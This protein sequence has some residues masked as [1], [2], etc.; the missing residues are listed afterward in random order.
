MDDEVEDAPESPPFAELQNAIANLVDDGSMLAGFVV[1]AEWIE[2]DGR[3]T[4]SVFGSPMPPWHRYGMLSAARDVHAEPLV[5]EGWDED[6]DD[7]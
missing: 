5:L 1:V 4:M 3:E 2:A 7:F 6:E